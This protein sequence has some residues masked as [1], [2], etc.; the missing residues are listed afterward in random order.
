MLRVEVLDWLREQRKYKAL[1]A[2]KA[3][4]AE[5]IRDVSARATLAPQVPVASVTVPA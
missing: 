5:D 4:L 2:L 3:Q 1:D